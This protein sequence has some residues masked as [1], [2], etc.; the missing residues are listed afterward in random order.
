MEFKGTK[1]KWE[2]VTNDSHQILIRQEHNL[3]A[4]VNREVG[5]EKDYYNAKLIAVAPEMLDALKHIQFCLESKAE[6]TEL[7]LRDIKKTIKKATT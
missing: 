2:A 7:T 4:Q 6:M 3:I 1:G 5:N